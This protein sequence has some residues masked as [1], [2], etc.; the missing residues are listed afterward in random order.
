MQEGGYHTLTRTQW[1]SSRS[2]IAARWFP[3]QVDYQ[4]FH[5]EKLQEHSITEVEIAE[6][7]CVVDAQLFTWEG[8][9]L[10]EGKL[11]SRSPTENDVVAFINGKFQK[12][13]WA[14]PE[15]VTALRSSKSGKLI[16]VLV[17]GLALVVL[18]LVRSLRFISYQKGS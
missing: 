3:K 18:F 14:D 10:P 15:K 17:G 11:I 7:N 4:R 5:F 6:L 8:M 12:K 1:E 13:I 9:M 2:D 16:A